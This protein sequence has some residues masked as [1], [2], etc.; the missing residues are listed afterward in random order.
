MYHRYNFEKQ[1]A[2]GKLHA[3]ERIY[4]IVDENSF[5]EIQSLIR[6]DCRDFGLDKLDIPYD[7]VI[8]GFGEV[9]GKQIGIY[10]QDFTIMGGS[11]GKQHGIKIANLI[12]LCIKARCPVIGIND[13]G[14]A[15]IQEGVHSLAGYGE[16][17]YQN[18][19]ASGIIPQISI[20]AGPCAGGAVYSPGLTDFVVVIDKVSN[21]FVTGPKVVKSVTNED[22][23]S[24]DLGGSTVHA[25]KSGVA[26][27]RCKDEISAYV[28][29]RKLLSIVP[30]NNNCTTGTKDSTY[31]ESQVNIDKILPPKSNQAY[32]MHLIIHALSDV[33]TFIEIQKEFARNVIVGLCRIKNIRIGIVAS[34]PNYMAGVIDIDASDKIARFVRYCDAFNIPIVTLTDVPGFMPGLTQEARGIIRHGAKVLFAYSEASVPKINIIIRK[35]Y[36][37]AYIAM[38]SK[39]LGADFVFA[40]PTAEI[41]VMGAEG[42]V[43]ILFSKE[44]GSQKNTSLYEDKI[45]EYNSKFLSPA[46]AA[47]YG[48]IDEVIQPMESRDVLYH[49]L[50]LLSNK[51]EENSNYKKHGNIPL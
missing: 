49:A 33:N 9:D 19:K 35:A 4:K 51:L 36:G 46:I 42:A 13:S 23:T 37:G 8:V 10:S 27:F 21:M 3:I 40:W 25:T 18:T 39:H 12:K 34:Q 6:T 7:G 43:E 16:I 41:A 22:V 50:N 38:S 44:L 17:F 15:R 48:Y 5:H 14:G 2:K 47:N 32:D 30:H 20:I 24:D 28:L 1:H 31:E 11:L 45:K 29:V 26:H